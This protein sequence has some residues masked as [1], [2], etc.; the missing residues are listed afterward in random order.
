MLYLPSRIPYLPENVLDL[1]ADNDVEST[2]ETSTSLYIKSSSNSSRLL[3]DGHGISKPFYENDDAPIHGKLYEFE[4]PLITRLLMFA[5]TVASVAIFQLVGLSP[6]MD[7]VLGDRDVLK[8]RIVYWT[9]ACSIANSMMLFLLGRWFTMDLVWNFHHKHFRH[10]WGLKPSLGAITIGIHVR[11]KSTACVGIIIALMSVASL[12]LSLWMTSAMEIGIYSYYPPLSQV[13]LM[14]LPFV[15]DEMVKF[16]QGG[17]HIFDVF[18]EQGA[19]G[20]LGKT[21]L[22]P[23][24]NRYFWSPILVSEVPMTAQVQNVSAFSIK[25]SCTLLTASDLKVPYKDTN[26]DRLADRNFTLGSFQEKIGPVWARTHFWDVHMDKETT[27]GGST[28]Q[29]YNILST[30]SKSAGP[31]SFEI[32]LNSANGAVAYVYAVSCQVQFEAWKISGF[33]NSFRPQRLNITTAEQ[34]EGNDKSMIFYILRGLDMWTNSTIATT[35]D[36]I[37]R[38][39]Q[40]NLWMWMRGRNYTQKDGDELVTSNVSF[41]VWT[42]QKIVELVAASLTTSTAAIFNRVVTGAAEIQTSILNVQT[43]RIWIGLVVQ[44]AFVVVTVGIYLW[45]RV[46]NIL[47]SDDVTLLL[48]KDVM[49]WI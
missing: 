44:L 35:V 26:L 7:K 16:G 19:I 12:G 3:V 45:C 49:P 15:G 48:Q 41:P 6:L 10:L 17:A 38:D 47:R 4:K 20:Y 9:T 8:Q 28:D 36:N 33:I 24:N 29:F 5:V 23:Y 31:A 22:T 43:F 18:V 32:I 1:V 46:A 13:N 40:S 14:D 25:P 27:D 39:L 30:S 37:G 11:K 2:A 21:Q 34:V 42:E